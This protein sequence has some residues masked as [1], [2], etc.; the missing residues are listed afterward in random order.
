[1]R[2]STPGRLRSLMMDSSE[3]VLLLGAGASIT[4]GIPGAEKTV[5]KLARW[6][7]CKENGRYPEDFTIRRSDYW[8]WLT[9]QSWYKAGPP[10]ADLYP[11][12]IDNLLG[13]KSD[14]REFFERLINPDV[15]PSRG[16]TALTQI[17]HQ[18][19]ISTVLTTN[20][21]Q[22]L[23]KAAIQQN[24]PHRLVSIS[25]PADYVMFNS[26]PQD[27]QLV[28]LHGSVQHYTDKN[29]TDEVDSLDPQLVDRLRPLL[30]DHPVVVVG[31]R[32][33]ERSVMNDLFLTQAR[34]GGF[35]HGVYWCVLAPHQNDPFTPLVDQ[36]AQQIG[37]N[38]QL[39]PITG[40]DDLFEKDLLT[41]MIAAGARPTR[42]PSGHSAGHL[43]SDMRPLKDLE[44]SGFE[45]PLLRARLQQYADKTDLWRPQ[46]PDSAWLEEMTD[47]L[48]LVRPVEQLRVPTLAGWLL[49]A[50]NP[51]EQF[52]QARVEF[53]ATGP[54]HWLRARFGDD[55]ELDA[56][57]GGEFA[58]HRRIVGNLWSQLDRLLDLLALVNFQFRL[59]AEVSRTVSAYDAL[60]IKEMIVNA[61]VHRDYD[62]DEAVQVIVEPKS[63]TVVSPGGLIDEIAVQVGSQSFQNAVA[64]RTGPIKGYR[65]PAI[66]DLFYGGGQMDRRGSGLSDMVMSTV[67]NNG[68]V[69]FGPSSDNRQFSVTIEA[70]PEA[71]DEITNTAVPIAEETVRYSS[72]LV[73]FEAMPQTVWHAGTTATSNRSFYRNARELAV[74]PGHVSDGRFY[75]FY[76]LEKLAEAMVTPF[77]PGDIETLGFDELLAMPGGEAIALKL[78][79]ELLFEHIK[80]KGLQIE[81]DRRRAYYARGDE[82]EVKISYQGRLRKATRTVV[83]ARTKRDSDEVVY[84]E[85][86]AITFSVMRFSRD[87]SVV[88]TPG[89][90][91]TRDGVA[92]PISRKRTNA[93]STRRA[94]RDFN[95]NV[96]QDVSFWL[97]VLS[98]ESEGLFA[99][100]HRDDNDLAPF[101]PMVLLSNRMP[102]I[103]FNIS[104]FSETAERDAKI[105]EDLEELEEE[106]EELAS[107]PSDDE[108]QQ[109]EPGEEP[110]EDNDVD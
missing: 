15:P 36:L 41:A 20:F 37:S 34:N 97:A 19:W 14:R 70:R 94:A 60:A 96:L 44:I 86:K 23:Q 62:R 29:L 32:G 13:V 72:N 106:L 22:C 59:K 27:P 61:I 110:G 107:R 63:I 39:V 91:F 11:Q 43:P 30:R 92:K 12:A 82:P 83:K 25:T 108:P 48:D 7:W 17:L 9:A 73:P 4:S 31:Y 47:R 102:T 3:P 26:A 21:D 89:Y 57:T 6:A 1:M 58:V 69:S 66:S 18:G 93:L 95:P 40:F 78:L 88:L 53:C 28:F 76:D 84:Y 38:F 74:P 35:L 67:N 79:H 109:G 105:D 68:S 71:V 103:S 5:D 104:A 90:A 46:Q 45:A 64:E 51:T 16:Y 42:R 99:L 100:E 52:P 49:F 33:S 2:M 85:H 80:S 56:A 75:S 24:R 55:V 8:P 81:F 50:P 10:L 77:D 65:N 98:G 101:A 87:W 54:A